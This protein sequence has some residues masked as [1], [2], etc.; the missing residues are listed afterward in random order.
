MPK[1]S[2]TFILCMFCAV[3]LC[4]CNLSTNSTPWTEKNPSNPPE[5]PI[6]APKPSA[7]QLWIEKK[8]ST[9][10]TE[11]K[12]GQLFFVRHH[13]ET[14][15]D[16]AAYHLGGVLLFGR[17]FKGKTYEEVCAMTQTLQASARIPL[18][19]GADE[20]GGTVVRASSNSN[21]RSS[22][23]AAPQMVYQKGGLDALA[24]DARDKS[25]FLLALGVNVNLAPVCDL[26]AN[27]GDYIY[28]R[29]LGL[30]P[31][32]TAEGISSIVTA[33][34]A[35][36]IGS[37]LKHF[38]GYG[39]NADTHTG[40][41]LDTR[42]YETFLNG[43]FLPFRAGIDAGADSVLVSHNIVQCMD[44]T[45][46]ASLSAPVHEILRKELHFEGV[47]MTDDLAMDALAAYCTD[48]MQGALAV[49]AI[50]AGNDMIITTDYKNQISAVIAAVKSGTISQAQLDASV[51]R[52][53][54]WKIDLGLIEAAP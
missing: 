32:K 41:A 34:K 13:E 5:M 51:A 54:K 16:A 52:I 35:Q 14:A 10:S 42:P 9:M 3:L 24:A 48:E 39:G 27:T 22:K 53:L 21:L 8:L 6:P 18:L 11:E 46:P 45:L 19:I 7:E 2:S 20:E 31:E 40:T 15:A 30:S 4:S 47:I 50:Q 23:F 12:V 43:D 49:L 17:D 1:F 37:V 36:H 33:M 25:D 44:E 29:T 26:S 38:P 28:A